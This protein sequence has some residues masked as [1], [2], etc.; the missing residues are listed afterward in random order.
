[1][2]KLS[3][4]HSLIAALLGVVVTGTA[5]AQSAARMDPVP[6]KNWKVPSIETMMKAYGS[7]P[8]PNVTINPGAFVFQSLVPCRMVDTRGGPGPFGVGE[9]RVYSVSFAGTCPGTLPGNIAAVSANFTVVNTAGTGFVTGFPTGASLPAVSTVNWIGANAIVSNAAIV[10]TSSGPNSNISVYASQATDVII[11]INGI[12]IS[13][14]TSNG[15]TLNIISNVP[16]GATLIGQNDS[17]AGLSIGVLGHITANPAGGSSAAVRGQNDG[18]GGGGIGVWGSQNGSGYGVYGTA[19]SGLGVF[20]NTAG[21]GISVGGVWGTSSNALG[22]YGAST[23]TNGIWAQ[24]T[25]FDALAA[26]GGRDGAY[27][28]GARYGAIG[29]STSSTSGNAG[30]FGLIDGVTYPANSWGGTLAILGHASV[31]GILGKASSAGGRGVQGC[32]VNGTTGLCLTAGVLGYTGTSGVHSFNDVTAGGAKPFVV[33]YEGDAAKQIVFV[34]TEADEVLTA[35]RGRVTLQR[36]LSVIKVP[37]HFLKV[38]EPEGWSVQLTPIGEMAALA[39]TRIDSNNGEIEVKASEGVEAFYR[40]EGIRRGY[41][42]FQPVQENTYFV[43]ASATAKMDN[44]P[45][46]TQKILIQNKIYNED[47]TPNIE[48]GRALGWAQVWENEANARAAAIKTL[49]AAASK[50]RAEQEKTGKQ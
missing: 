1:M 19:T 8:I 17:G 16:G 32:R 50:T 3:I 11:D 2:K 24:S 36:G 35:T 15:D 39:V 47:G 7:T 13:N 12:F 5:L 49:E 18:A 43:P 27:L 23:N 41:K 9:T 25:N 30:L 4:E 42:D 26:F 46:Q 21:S 48:T 22:V 37:G 14:I 10:P 6:V 38:T 33:P 31:Y 40:V 28:Q 29:A 20:G 34:A 44:W 45:A